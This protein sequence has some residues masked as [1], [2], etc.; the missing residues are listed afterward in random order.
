MALF[1]LLYC[2]YVCSEA[3]SSNETIPSDCSRQ[4]HFS[5]AVENAKRLG[6]RFES[7]SERQLRVKQQ[8]YEM[9]IGDSRPNSTNDDSLFTVELEELSSEKVIDIYRK[10]GGKGFA[11]HLKSYLVDLLKRREN[12]QSVVYV[13]VSVLARQTRA[14]ETA[15]LPRLLLEITLKDIFIALLEVMPDAVHSR[16]VSLYSSLYCAVPFA[17]VLQLSVDDT[18]TV[19]NFQSLQ[20]VLA[21]PSHPLVVSCGTAN[22]VRKGKSTL[23]GKLVGQLETT[24]LGFDSFDVCSDEG[25]GGLCHSPS[26]DLLLEVKSNVPCG[27]NFADVHGFTNEK[28]FCHALSTLCSVAA[29]V[30]VHVTANDFGPGGSLDDSLRSFLLNSCNLHCSNAKIA[31]FVRDVPSSAEMSPT[32]P[33]SSSINQSLG[34]IF[35]NRI[36]QVVFVEDLAK[37]RTQEQRQMTVIRIKDEMA[38]IFDKLKQRL[39]CSEV[40]QRCFVSC[41]TGQGQAYKKESGRQLDGFS[42]LGRKVFE[43]LEASNPKKTDLANLLFPLT[44]IYASMAKIRH[45]E[46]ELQE[47]EVTGDIHVELAKLEQEMR[48]LQTRRQTIEISHPVRLFIVL[49]SIKNRHHLAEFQHYLEVWKDRYIDPLF[50]ERRELSQQ[51]KPLESIRSTGQQNSKEGTQHKKDDIKRK[52][53]EVSFC[54]DQ[55]DISIDS[56]WNELMELCALLEDDKIVNDHLKKLH[57]DPQVIKQV[58]TQCVL[59]GYPMQLLRGNQLQM[60]ASK[61]IQDIMRQ[62]GVEL[63]NRNNLVVVSVIGAQSSGKSTLLNYLFGCGFATRTGRCTKGLYAS[64][65][66]ISDGRYLLVLDSEGLLSLE[67]GGHVFDNQITVMAMACSDAVIVNHKGEITTQIK[68]LLEICLY[69][70]DYLKLTDIRT[71]MMFVLRDQR[72]RDTKVQSDS[73][74]LLRKTLKEAMESGQKDLDDLVSLRQDAIFLLPNAFYETKQEGRT[75]ESPS[76]VFSEEAFALR[77]KILRSTLDD[78]SK[79]K[80]PDDC[81]PL[82]DWYRHACIVWDTLTEY[83]YTLLHYK[84]LDELHLHKEMNKI[85]TSLVKPAESK[86]DKQARAVLKKHTERLH[87]ARDEKVVEK[88]DLECRAELSKLKELMEDELERD[89]E[90]GTQAKRYNEDLKEKFRCKLTTPISSFYEFHKYSWLKQRQLASDRLKSDRRFHE[91][92][93]NELKRTEYESSLST[94]DAAKLFDESW[95]RYETNY[96]KHLEEIKKKKEDIEQEIV[97]TFRDVLIRHRI[98]DKILAV[99]AMGSCSVELLKSTHFSDSSHDEWFDKYLEITSGVV[100][101]AQKVSNTTEFGDRTHDGW[102]GTLRKLPQKLLHGVLPK[103][104]NH[105]ISR[106][107]VTTRVVPRMR[108]EVENLRDRVAAKFESEDGQCDPAIVTDVVVRASKIVNEMQPSLSSFNNRLKL[109]LAPFTNDLIVYLQRVACTAVCSAD[110]KRRAEEKMQLET[111]RLKKRQTFLTTVSDEANDLERAATFAD[112][113]SRQLNVW[114]KSKVQEF[115]SEVLGQVQQEMPN[116]EYATKRA[117]HSSFTVGNYDAV[118]EYCIDVNAY[119]KKLFMEMFE[120]RKQVTIGKEMRTLE[121]SVSQMYKAIMDV[122]ERWR[123]SSQPSGCLNNFKAYLAKCVDDSSESAGSRNLLMVALERFPQITN[124]PISKVNNFCEK[125]K[126]SMRKLLTDVRSNYLQETLE[127]SMIDERERIWKEIKG[128]QAKCPLCCS[129]CSLVFEHKDHYC[130]HHIF[131]AFRGVRVRNLNYPVFDR[132]LS[133]DTAR[134]RRGRGDDP[135][136][137]NLAAFL[138]HYDDC[139]SWKKSLVPDPTLPPLPVQQIAAWVNCR[140]PLLKYWNLVDNTPDEWLIYQSKK[141]LEED[142]C[143]KA[144]ARLE[145]Y[146]DV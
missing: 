22:A 128:C 68:E 69:A 51:M 10:C 139:R 85:V 67:G 30:L 81:D 5:N 76:A 23:T 56:F 49:V 107:E 103:S 90:K 83:G 143:D 144:R 12:F 1:N 21:V 112:E 20:D 132:C 18:R 36:A 64:F 8:F 129:K 4:S 106:E 31:I 145:K 91:H 94:S 109:R 131:P 33:Q 96:T 42:A 110:D 101:T 17:Y 44:A 130:A 98:D 15:A 84:A 114:V 19:T 58:Y 102:F 124:F 71:E 86:F 134:K 27:L 7:D 93:E 29:L 108:K 25:D 119:L 116:A 61:F 137:P 28:T 43:A 55:F 82:V 11:V 141:P 57:L 136:L 95:S 138:D 72:D 100:D 105:P 88:Y 3:S 13:I 78:H 89:F 111:K 39:P 52:L 35:P 14:D 142:E 40:I 92:L 59:E 26:I 47:N 122:A 53:K 133:T 77:R 50:K 87:T 62:L 140:K 80:P 73:L 48:E 118:L 125:F 121:N 120:N 79:V 123:Q 34:E 9:M 24:S 60:T 117:Y 75:V 16:L 32:I 126:V 127:S 37:C 46:K 65:V 74:T 70:M 54:I 135:F 45:Q 41:C 2:I 6:R 38:P 113:Y 104:H 146:H 97:T 115:A 99:V 66:S 63:K